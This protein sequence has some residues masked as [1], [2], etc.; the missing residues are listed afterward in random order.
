M[1]RNASRT[2]LDS[3]KTEETSSIAEKTRGDDLKKP[4]DVDI[5]MDTS[6]KFDIF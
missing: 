6:K 1:Q 5:S 3:R 2:T 4:S